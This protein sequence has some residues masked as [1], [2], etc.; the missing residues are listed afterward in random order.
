MSEAKESRAQNPNPG[1]GTGF[2]GCLFGGA[3]WPVVSRGAPGDGDLD[4]L[5]LRRR[6]AFSGC[7]SRRAVVCL[8]RFLLL[9]VMCVSKHPPGWIGIDQNQY[10]LALPNRLNCGLH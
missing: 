1:T 10:P 9:V 7:G 3:V 2:L 5:G 6:T 4:A 8:D